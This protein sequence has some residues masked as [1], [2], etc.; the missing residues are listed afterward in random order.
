MTLDDPDVP[1]YDN[2]F[3]VKIGSKYTVVYDG[4]SIRK[5]VTCVRRKPIDLYGNYEYIF[6]EKAEGYTDSLYPLKQGIPR[7]DSEMS[8]AESVR[9]THAFVDWILTDIPADSGVVVCLPMIKVKEGLDA[10]KMVIDPNIADPSAPV[11]RGRVGLQFFSEAWGAAL[12]TIP[13]KE[14]VGTNVL[15]LNFG[16]S[17]IEVTLHSSKRLI[18]ANVFTFGGTEIDKGLIAAITHQYR[19]ECDE[20]TAR[21]IKERYSLVENN[22]IP[23]V[24]LSIEGMKHEV[25]IEGDVIHDVV[26]SAI[27]KIV[28]LVRTRFLRAAEM[29][30][31]AAVSSLQANGRGYIVLCGGMV[32]MEG[33]ADELYKRL[34][35]VGAI[36]PN[37]ILAIPDDG[38]I[39]PAIGA[40]KVGQIL[41][42]KR[43]ELDVERWRNIGDSTETD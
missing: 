13:V 27:D 8:I 39:A 36:N 31:A 30:D 18:E 32:N 19:A 34:V 11:V 24:D 23:N 25:T 40:W 17:T 15:T 3:G 14:A 41:E 37:V 35:D 28:K 26:S 5:E 10:L 9:L 21:G 16:S 42:Q 33:F 7:N 22:S 4:E 2:I 20:P 29:K 43:R 38:V 6:G 1:D 12:G